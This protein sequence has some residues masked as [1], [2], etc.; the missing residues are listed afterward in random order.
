MVKESN[1]IDDKDF[2]LR[3]LISNIFSMMHPVTF[4]TLIVETHYA[5]ENNILKGASNTERG[6]YFNEVLLRDN[7][8]RKEIY[9]NYPELVRILDVRVKNIIEYIIKIINDTESEINEI[10][11]RLNNNENLGKI[12]DIDMSE[13]DTH[14]NYLEKLSDN[15]KYK[16]ITKEI[17]SSIVEVINLD[18]ISVEDIDIGAFSGLAGVAYLLFHIDDSNKKN[19]YEKTIL[20]IFGLIESKINL[21]INPDVTRDAGIIGSMISIYE[22]LAISC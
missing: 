8:Y 6:N 1:I 10:K 7:E 16:N 14:F 13:G 18:D 9:Q 15:P 19:I 22:N 11:N 4:Q 20:Q 12:K 3:K 5:K 2:L 21:S 17:C